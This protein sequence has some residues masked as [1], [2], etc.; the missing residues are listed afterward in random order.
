LLA[1]IGSFALIVD[2][3]FFA[4]P[5]TIAVCLALLAMRDEEAKY[6]PPAIST[7]AYCAFYMVGGRDVIF[8]LGGALLQCG[9]LL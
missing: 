5:L 7:F 9:A 1:K 3:V 6:W 4:I 8:Y 2:L